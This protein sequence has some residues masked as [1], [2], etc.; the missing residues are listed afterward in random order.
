MFDCKCIHK[1]AKVVI[2]SLI[3]DKILIIK[4]EIERKEKIIRQ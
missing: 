2:N 4:T 3:E 1:D